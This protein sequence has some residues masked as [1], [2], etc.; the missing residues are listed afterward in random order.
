MIEVVVYAE[1]VEAEEWELYEEE[2][3]VAVCCSYCHYCC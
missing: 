3:R 2:V 1:G